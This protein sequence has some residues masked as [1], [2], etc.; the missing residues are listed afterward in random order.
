MAGETSVT[1]QA[2]ER[3]HKGLDKQVETAERRLNTHFETITDLKIIVGQLTQLLE[4]TTN[5]L[6][7]A[8]K[9]ATYLEQTG[10]FRVKFTR[11][12]DKD[13]CGDHTTMRR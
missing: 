11:T 10:H 12:T 8:K 6:I 13:F 9:T 3:T 5:V 7:L 1:E 4:T 2:C